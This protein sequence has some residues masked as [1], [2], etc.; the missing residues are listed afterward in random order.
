MFHSAWNSLSVQF[1]CPHQNHEPLFSCQGR[2][3]TGM[4][5]PFLSFSEARKS[6]TRFSHSLKSGWHTPPGMTAFTVCFGLGTRAA[7]SCWLIRLRASVAASYALMSFSIHAVVP[8]M[9][10]RGCHEMVTMPPL[11]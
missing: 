9:G 1:F 8:S 5:L 7:M 10:L 3:M 11:A 2:K 6:V 4:A